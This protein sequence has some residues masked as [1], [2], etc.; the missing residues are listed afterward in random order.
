MDMIKLSQI[1]KN[2]IT[3]S[4]PFASLQGLTRF[5]LSGLLSENK[6]GRSIPRERNRDFQVNIS[7]QGLEREYITA[8]RALAGSPRHRTAYGAPDSARSNSY[9]QNSE[10]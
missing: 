9:I 4:N 2:L 8:G 1:V 7:R 3:Y 5:A 10:E 6:S